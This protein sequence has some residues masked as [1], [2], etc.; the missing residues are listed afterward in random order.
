MQ[1][2]TLAMAWLEGSSRARTTPIHQGFSEKKRETFLAAWSFD[3]RGNIRPSSPLKTVR[4]DRLVDCTS[5]HVGGKRKCK[6]GRE[7]C[8]H[9]GETSKVARANSAGS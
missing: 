1:D 8:S 4:V 2:S 9:L 6:K 5:V 7:A 3:S